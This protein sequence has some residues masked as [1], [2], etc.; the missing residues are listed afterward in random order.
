MLGPVLTPVYAHLVPAPPSRHVQR[1]PSLHLTHVMTKSV[2]WQ[3][4][5]MFTAAPLVPAVPADDLQEHAQVKRYLEAAYEGILPARVCLG[6]RPGAPVQ[7]A[8]KGWVIFDN[9]RNL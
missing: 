4:L 8:R 1:A 5:G 3:A 6:P 7:V 9:V 2:T